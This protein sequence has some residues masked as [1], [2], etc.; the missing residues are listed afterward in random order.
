[1]LVNID[2][3]CYADNKYGI[4]KEN[5]KKSFDIKTNLKDKK[6]DVPVT[7]MNIIGE[8]PDGETLY[9]YYE[10]ING[11][12]IL[13]GS[14]VVNNSIFTFDADSVGVI[15]VLDKNLESQNSGQDVNTNPGN[16]PN[17][18]NIEGDNNQNDNTNIIN[19]DE[20]LNSQENNEKSVI[21]QSSRTGDSSVG[22]IIV[23]VAMMV[24]TGIAI[25]VYSRRRKENSK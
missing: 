5:V 1:M 12:L 7:I 25:V 11:N 8:V 24:L 21:G 6:L 18:S 20:N 9:G 13:G 10:D 3:F 15:Y 16:N 4:N 2:N 22:S 23:I 17:N 19:G 14:G